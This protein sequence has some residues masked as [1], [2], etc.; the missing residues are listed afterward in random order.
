LF[1]LLFICTAGMNLRAQESG[2]A[3]SA[4]EPM[5]D[6]STLV[7]GGGDGGEDPAPNITPIAS[8][9]VWDFLRM[10]LVLAIV[11]GL[12]YGLFH[13]IKKAGGPRDDG[14]RFIRVLETRPLAGSRHLHLVEVGNEVLLIGSAEN[15]VCL[16]SEVSDKQT[17]DSIRL[18][19]SRISPRTGNFADALKGFFGG[20]K[21]SP[22]PA[23]KPASEE[24]GGGEASLEFMRKQKNRLKKLF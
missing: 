12:I 15:G 22:R 1:I 20:G 11:V 2:G 14:I 23:E 13:F 8:F 18:A 7:L 19:A 4:P 9:G 10:V 21:A 5:T 6:E 16:V 17:L 24:A 3:V